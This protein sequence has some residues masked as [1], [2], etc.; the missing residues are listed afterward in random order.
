[1]FENE[2]HLHLWGK[3]WDKEVEGEVGGEG[4]SCF[5]S[6][7]EKKCCSRAFL[8]ILYPP[9]F[10]CS[11]CA[12]PINCEQEQEEQEQELQQE[13]SGDK[14]RGKRVNLSS[15]YRC[16]TCFLFSPHRT[17]DICNT[18]FSSPP[19]SSPPPCPVS[20]SFHNPKTHTTYIQFP[21][22]SLPPPS[23]LPPPHPSLQLRPFSLSLWVLPFQTKK[24]M[25]IFDLGWLVICIKND[26]LGVSWRVVPKER[27]GRKGEER[28]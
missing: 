12:K 10:T 9:P 28:L 14:K 23:L 27:R 16:T 21:C 4:G 13:D 8:L 22:S 6:P 11:S 20:S 17:H 25:T 15:R 7:F 24:K 19:S 26:L 5:L 1:M 3:G 2:L 18:C